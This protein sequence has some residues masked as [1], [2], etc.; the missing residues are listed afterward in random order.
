VAPVAGTVVELAKHTEGGVVRP[1][2]RL[3]DIV[4]ADAELIVEARVRPNDIDEVHAGLVA[5]VHL[6]A[7]SARRLPR[8]D[9]RVRSVSADR[10]VDPATGEA[11]FATQVQ[12]APAALPA[13][14]GLAPGMPAEVVIV[15]AE[16]TLLDY[17]L[18]PIRTVLRRGMRE[19]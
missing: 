1:G 3:L 7:Y 5:Q 16:R 2:E 4:P 13:G 10:L 6:S 18:E 14:V 12:I 19:S 9:G 15:T 8:I 17:L 11:Y